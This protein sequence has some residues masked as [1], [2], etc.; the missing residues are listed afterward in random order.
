MVVR[1]LIVDGVEFQGRFFN[2]GV[3]WLKEVKL[4]VITTPSTTLPAS[5]CRQVSSAC[6]ITCIPTL[7]RAACVINDNRKKKKQYAIAFI[8]L[9]NN[10][11]AHN[12]FPLQM[13]PWST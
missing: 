2:K 10:D 11:K 13:S 5:P 6:T 8:F 9:L 4:M 1:R 12:C 7:V 3:K